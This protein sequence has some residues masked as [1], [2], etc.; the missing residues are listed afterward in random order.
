MIITQRTNSDDKN[1]QE[2]VKAL[3]H[4]LRIRDGK[5]HLFLTA[6]NKTDFLKYVIV[7]YDKYEP[8]GCGALR[9]YSEDAMEVKRMFVP[10]NKRKQGIASIVLT[11]LETW[12]MELNFKKCVLETGKNQPEAISFYIKNNYKIIP[13]F[14]RYKDVENSICFEKELINNQ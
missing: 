9:E 3:D 10:L 11:A 5:E 7:A 4:E 1:F 2:L 8:V 13:N 12:C 6:L 14:G